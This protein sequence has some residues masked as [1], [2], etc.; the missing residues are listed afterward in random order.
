MIFG[1]NSCFALGISVYSVHMQVVPFLF[2]I[3]V[4][5]AHAMGDFLWT[6]M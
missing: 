1:D 3:H 2:A 5:L 4:E 6:L